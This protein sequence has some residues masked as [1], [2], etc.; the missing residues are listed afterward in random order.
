MRIG[1]LSP[2]E[3]DLILLLHSQ[4]RVRKRG[5]VR[6]DRNGDKRFV[7]RNSPM[8]VYSSAT[9]VERARKVRKAGKE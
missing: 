8:S 5:K 2:G 7:T 3:Y 1:D 4:E 6:L 9:K